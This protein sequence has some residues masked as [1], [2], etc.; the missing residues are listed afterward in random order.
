MRSD[1][2]NIL[3][4]Q[5]YF[6]K[7]CHTVS[8]YLPYYNMGRSTINDV[9]ILTWIQWC[10]SRNINGP[11]H[12]PICTRWAIPNIFLPRCYNAYKLLAP[13]QPTFLST[14]SL[15]F[16]VQLHTTILA[17]TEILLWIRSIMT[18]IKDFPSAHTPQ[19]SVF[20]F[21]WCWFSCLTVTVDAA[22]KGN[23]DP[24]RSLAVLGEAQ[25]VMVRRIP[26]HTW[27]VAQD[28]LGIFS[29]YDASQLKASSGSDYV[30]KSLCSKFS[31]LQSWHENQALSNQQTLKWRGSD[32]FSLRSIPFTA[33]R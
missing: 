4:Y 33:L 2:N 18:E 32:M 9:E 5:N 23:S 11:K 12:I 20:T 24:R 8:W 26:V 13:M 21:E 31:T 22:L 19:V 17:Q 3:H 15:I 25:K 16:I 29:L 28:I 30:E 6:F 1:M 14:N 7:S 27:R 10:V